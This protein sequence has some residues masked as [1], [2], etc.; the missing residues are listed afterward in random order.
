MP[1]RFFSRPRPLERVRKRYGRG[2]VSIVPLL[3]LLLLDAVLR[4]PHANAE[5]LR[6][7][8]HTINAESTFSACAAIDV[9][10]DGR[11]DIVSGAYWY[12]APR[13]KHHHVRK[14]EEIRG[15]FDGYSN[16]PID[17]NG[18]GWTDFVS[19]NFR[20]RKLAW[21]E[22]PG[23]TLG[24]WSE[25]VID[26]PGA[27]E[28]GRLIDV[29]GDGDLDLLPNGRGFVAWWDIE[30]A[31]GSA[32][33]TRH[34]LP[35]EADGHG[36][37]FGDINGDG[38]GDIVAPLGWLQAP[39]DRHTGA[40]LWH[41]EFDLGAASIPILVLD[42]EG[43]GDQDIVWAR[44]HDFGLYWLEQRS[45]GRP[46]RW[47]HHTIDSSWSQGHA[48]LA[49]DLDGNGKIEIVVGK[50]YMAHD[51]K[52]PGA[53][54]PLVVYSY[55]FVP[56]S[57]TWRR[58]AISVGADVGFG[59]DPKAVDLDADGD[60][61]LIAPGRSGLF[62][63]ENLT[64]SRAAPP[65]RPAMAAFYPD[66]SDLSV[67]MNAAGAR[68]TIGTARDWGRRR[69]HVLEGAQRAMGRF[70]ETT[71]RVPLDVQVASEVDAGTYLRRTIT[72]A[73]ESGDRVPAYL[74][75]PKKLRAGRRNAAML[76][77][78][79]TVR[80]GKDE[81]AGLGGRPSLHYA[82]ELAERGYICLVPDYP[83]FGSYEYDFE[84][85]SIHTRYA[86]GTMKAIWN[87]VRAIDLLESLPQVNP[88]RIGCIGHSLG[89]HNAIFSAVF[90]QRIR[91]V[92]SSCGFTAFH[93][94]YEGRLAGWT[95]DRYMPR[96]RDVYGNNPDR[97]PFD[98]YEFV[99]ALAPRPFFICAPQ[100]DSNFD[101]TGV[102]KVV[103][104]A[105]RV[106]ALQDASAALTARYPDSEHD[107][108]DA[109]RYEAYE[110]LERMFEKG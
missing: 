31:K 89:G 37:G 39:R 3:A 48:P 85:S 92:I 8:K 27:M 66:H 13:W 63:L 51:G 38:R 93:H 33:W 98:F 6:F 10:H 55:E 71:R 30:A 4:W 107:F 90:D 29:D 105:R 87:N 20:S 40:W 47:N 82:H 109:T 53:Y 25:H 58:R 17:L 81:P 19:A 70:P 2:T 34:D 110:W 101:V 21:I 23:A 32:T 77:L 36:I 78:H 79:Q 57:S 88:R 14:V 69:S 7:K 102:R 64:N 80:L 44:G 28:T 50:R 59:L 43:D 12:E 97:V 24:T 68:Q 86:S 74:L 60:L 41:E 67:W 9:N 54:D 108:P 18:D 26:R 15:R 61:D 62:W 35:S 65:V 94:Y 91:A 99:A 46:R 84:Q 76:C 45:D 72:F 106:Y 16:Q 11:L 73:A 1:T 52:D 96:I 100:H 5:D 49:A 83:S 104:A 22:H 75:L 56:D 42:V 95:S 103:D